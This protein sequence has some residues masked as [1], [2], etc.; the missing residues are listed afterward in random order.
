MYISTS[1]MVQMSRS[2]SHF[3]CRRMVM[4]ILLFIVDENN[5]AIEASS[6]EP[7]EVL[8]SSISYESIFLAKSLAYLRIKHYLCTFIHPYFMPTFSHLYYDI[9]M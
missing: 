3:L 8:I 7:A 1:A 5:A 6:L 9:I 2:R 4:E